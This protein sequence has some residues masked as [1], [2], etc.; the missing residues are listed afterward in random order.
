[1]NRI[2]KI[3]I[4]GIVSLFF[5]CDKD[6]EISNCDQTV[7]ICA[8]EFENAPNFPAHIEDMRIEGNCLTIKFST[9]GCDM[10]N[11]KL[12]AGHLNRG[13]GNPFWTMRLSFDEPGDCD[14]WITKEMSFGI[15]GLQL[16]GRN[17]VR[18]SFFGLNNGILYEY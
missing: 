13:S 15:E 16:Q 3:G 8:D 2:I 1:M 6:K 5:G 18:L 14:D 17:S 9:S 4:I 11:I 10:R 12:I 7:I